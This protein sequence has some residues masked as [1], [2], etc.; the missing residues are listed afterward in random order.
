MI[1]TWVTNLWRQPMHSGEIV[2]GI[3]LIGA[4]SAGLIPGYAQDAG[5]YAFALANGGQIAWSVARLVVG[6]LL[7]GAAL[8]DVVTSRRWSYAIVIR[9]CAL[10]FGVA[11]FLALAVSFLQTGALSAAGLYC[12][13]AVCAS[14]AFLAVSATIR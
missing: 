8:H 1:R 6:S 4:G 10:V 13:V 7:V 14:W 12:G 11:M 9:S 5:I 3:I 2:M